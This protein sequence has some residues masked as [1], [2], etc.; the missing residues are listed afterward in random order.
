MFYTYAEEIKPHQYICFKLVI[1]WN[2]W[3]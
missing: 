1:L 2:K 3:L